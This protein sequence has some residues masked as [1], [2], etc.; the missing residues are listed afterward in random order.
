[1][2]F[3]LLLLGLQCAALLQVSAAW[4]CGRL[5]ECDC[6]KDLWIIC[7]DV[8]AAPNFRPGIRRHRS[9]M[10]TIADGNDFDMTSLALTNGFKETVLSIDTMDRQFC[11]DVI[12]RHPWIR[13]IMQQTTTGCP[14][15]NE[16][17]NPP[18]VH[19][20]TSD[21]ISQV[22]DQEVYSLNLEARVTFGLEKVTIG[23]E[24][25]QSYLSTALKPWLKSPTLFWACATLA[26]VLVIM[27][28]V[29]TSMLLT[30]KRRGNVSWGVKCLDCLCKLCLCPCK[31]L[32]KLRSRERPYH[33]LGLPM[34]HLPAND[35][36]ESIELYNR[37]R[38]RASR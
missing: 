14:H 15:G 30:K 11:G 8:K 7:S 9:L 13:C 4:R 37:E 22:P 33:D 34:Q 27:I 10:L 28:M 25:S 20:T 3:G 19:T 29:I 26:S 5:S 23:G 38:E 16:H 2:L 36:S 1:M 6:R 21:E 35:S 32:D 24:G 17:S 31:C 12:V 18:T